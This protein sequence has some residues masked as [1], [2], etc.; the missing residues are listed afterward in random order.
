MRGLIGIIGA[1]HV[2]VELLIERMQ[3]VSS[4]QLGGLIFH[5]GSLRGVQ[6]VVA[7]S[8]VGKVHAAMCAEAMAVHF[9]VDACI[10]TGIAG[11][12]A[13]TLGIGD[14]VVSTDV[15]HHDMDVSNLGYAK[16]QIPGVATR[17]FPADTKLISAVHHA[18][19]RIDTAHAITD[20][21]IASGDQFVC[22]QEQKR[23]IRDEFKAA[24]SEMEGASIGQVCYL[25][26]IPFVVVRT[27][28]DCA[29]ETS[30]IDYPSFEKTAAHTNA[31]LIEETLQVLKGMEL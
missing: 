18:Y 28:S 27:M 19:A 13:P 11:A 9:H 31:Q 20:G 1:M 4:V 15:V 3:N 24:A 22:T 29:D 7:Q 26:H 12:L 23:L 14:V 8:G 6:V 25:N 17:S 21:R 10:N 5:E 2:E 30:S 16:G